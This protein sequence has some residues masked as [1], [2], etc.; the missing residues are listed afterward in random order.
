MKRCVLHLGMPK[1]ASTTIQSYLNAN[2]SLVEN[3][4]WIYP[5]FTCPET[6]NIFFNHNDPLC[7]LFNVHHIFHVVRPVLSGEINLEIQQKGIRQQLDAVLKNSKNVILSSEVLLEVSSL[8]ELKEYVEDK[9]FEVYPILYLR[10]PQSFRESIYQSLLK[11]SQVTPHEIKED[12]KKPLVSSAVRAFLDVFHTKDSVFSYNKINRDAGSVV[13]HFFQLVFGSEQA[14]QIPKMQSV[15]ISPSWQ[16]TD[17]MRFIEERCPFFIDNKQNRKRAV[18][19]TVLLNSIDGQKFRFG[20]DLLEE[21]EDILGEENKFLKDNFGT[22][23]CDNASNYSTMDECLIWR[24]ENI[25]SLR[26]IFPDLDQH[27]QILIKEYFKKEA[28]IDSFLNRI[29]CIRYIR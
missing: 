25:H 1:T 22:S 16:G 26:M 29:R 28:K 8:K 21:L 19:D 10:S 20:D 15:N 12:L 14:C 24:K 7:R 11:F 23:F 6:G 17:L 9:G 2:R 13:S 27:I 3:W 5:E 18:S 4:G